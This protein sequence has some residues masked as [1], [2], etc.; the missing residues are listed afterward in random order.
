[1]DLNVT[2]SFT[3][4]WLALADGPTDSI[5]KG[6]GGVPLSICLFAA[7]A[8]ADPTPI[9]PW[10]YGRFFYRANRVLALSPSLGSNADFLICFVLGSP[11]ASGKRS[12]VICESASL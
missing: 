1:M 2:L 11:P 5:S 9:S 7:A 8:I 10:V 3:T 12:N 6:F 4:T